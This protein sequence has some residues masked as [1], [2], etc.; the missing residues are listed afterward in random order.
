MRIYFSSIL[1]FCVF[2]VL[3][4]QKITNVVARQEENS[5]IITYNLQCESFS[6]ISLFISTDGGNE[7]FG[8]L[9]NVVG[10]VGVGVKPGA[11]MITWNPLP[12]DDL[13][14][15]N[16]FVF[17]VKG[18]SKFGTI[19]D[20]RD[21]KKYKTVQIGRQIIMAENLNYNYGKSWCYDNS[22]YNCSVFGRLYD[23]QTA[24]VV[25]P[26]NWHL[27]S[28]EE[29]ELLLNDCGGEGHIA[30][31][32]LSPT[33]NSGFCALF[34]GYVFNHFYGEVEFAQKGEYDCFWSS[35]QYSNEDAFCLKMYTGLVAF[36]RVG[37]Y[38]KKS[39]YSVRC[40]KD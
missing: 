25:C 3:F 36:A 5:V 14:I 20:T 39:G 13:I 21:G 24:K 10:D 35:S 22:N 1:I 28:K 38:V 23:W 7:F 33:G 27:P 32:A 15:G 26:Y 30:L 6:E 4:A 17:R 8:P 18:F 37:Q 9:E 29:F 12:E 2:Q 16:N 31:E 34:G 40:F 19:I 11:K